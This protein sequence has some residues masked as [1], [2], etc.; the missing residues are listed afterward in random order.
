MIPGNRLVCTFE[1]K[2]GEAVIDR[3]WDEIK[4]IYFFEMFF[5]GEDCTYGCTNVHKNGH[6]RTCVSVCKV[7]SPRTK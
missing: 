3:K 2:F 6:V 5:H 4:E 1:Q 7:L